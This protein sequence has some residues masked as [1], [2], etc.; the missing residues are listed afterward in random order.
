[1]SIIVAGYA[2]VGGLTLI[3]LTSL[4]FVRHRC[5]GLFTICHYIGMFAFLIGLAYHTKVAVPWVI[6][7][8]ILFGLEQLLRIS[9]M[10]MMAAELTPLAG[11]DTTMIKV[12]GLKEGWRAGQHLILTV[13]SL[14]FKIGPRAFGGHPF[15]IASA[16][17]GT[18][19]VL[20]AK[21][22]SVVVNPP[23]GGR[24]VSHGLANRPRHP[25]R[26]GTGLTPSTKW[27]PALPRAMRRASEVSRRRY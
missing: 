27:P 2:S 4:P 21:N 15:T 6:A 22:V 23:P 3:V 16:P 11:A 5:Y 12:D 7:S 26:P 18:G 20:M 17:D 25:H 8:F 1:M 9:K 13:P 19:I 14:A 10:R 24:S